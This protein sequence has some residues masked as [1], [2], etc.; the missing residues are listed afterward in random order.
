MT[1]TLA[2]Q[3]MDV[4]DPGA[5]PGGQAD[6]K[7]SLGQLVSS[8]SKC[9]Y[10]EKAAA[11]KSG[12]INA[13]PDAF[14]SASIQAGQS[15]AVAGSSLVM[16]HEIRIKLHEDMQRLRN[17]MQR[18]QMNGGEFDNADAEA[19][20]E[21]INEEKH[22]EIKEEAAKNGTSAENG[23]ESE[24]Q[25]Q[26][27]K[28]TLRQI[29]SVVA[30]DRENANHAYSEFL[31]N[32]EKLAD[33]LEDIISPSVLGHHHHGRPLTPRGEQPLGTNP[34]FKTSI[35]GAASHRNQDRET[36]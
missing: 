26:D 10:Q 15:A 13:A 1:K 6:L 34:E 22:E 17:V 4:L 14:K 27:E 8:L 33:D 19:K 35:G 25:Y 28:L 12:V 20:H 11:T 9:R 5:I 36:R 24:N 23:E 2:I 21:E 3:I 30:K 18:I 31:E 7:K 16:W 29:M 32:T